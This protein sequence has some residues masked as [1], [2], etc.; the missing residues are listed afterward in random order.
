MGCGGFPAKYIYEVIPNKATCARY[1]IVSE[2]PLRFG[3][4]VETECPKSVFGFSFEDTPKVLNWV[5]KKQK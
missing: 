1:E 5:R 2:N 3:P 4:G